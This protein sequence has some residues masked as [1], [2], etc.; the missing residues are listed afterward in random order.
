MHRSESPAICTPVHRRG[1]GAADRAHCATSDP[2]PLHPEPRRGRCPDSQSLARNAG[3]GGAAGL[4]LG[5][6]AHAGHVVP[7]VWGPSSA[8]RSNWVENSSSGVRGNRP[9]SSELARKLLWAE[10][11]AQARLAPQIAALHAD[12]E[13]ALAVA[14]DDS[15]HVLTMYASHDDAWHRCGRTQPPPAHPAPCT[16]TSASQAAW[17]PFA[18]ST[19]AAAPSPAFRGREQPQPLPG[20]THLQ[21]AAAAGPA[22]AHRLC[23]AH[24]GADRCQ[25][26][27][28]GL[29]S[30]TDV[31]R[32]GARFANRP[33]GS[34]TRVSAGKICWRR[35]GSQASTS[36]ASNATK[37]RIPRWHR[38]WSAVRLTRAWGSRRPPA[39]GGWTSSRW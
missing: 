11:Q 34:G 30:L 28:L 38:P 19:R 29:E 26:N 1:P 31:A 37:P 3:G 27:P 33:L 23:A 7:T 32:T 5:R 6:S 12:L 13:R 22:Q 24:A 8:G 39:R 16:W 4:H 14:F 15:A 21:T 2:T 20:G 18:P 35:K 36:R 25:G 17:T 10:R 9:S